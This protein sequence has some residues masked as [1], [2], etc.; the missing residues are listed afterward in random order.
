R[1]SCHGHACGGSYMTSGS[2]CVPQ[3]SAIGRRPS[4][5]RRMRNAR[6]GDWITATGLYDEIELTCTCA[7]LG[8]TN[9]LYLV[10]ARRSWSIDPCGSWQGILPIPTAHRTLVDQALSA[11]P[12][13]TDADRTSRKVDCCCG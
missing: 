9:E 1:R 4:T 6:A 10:G 12:P 3:E 11:R 13:G 5:N 2:Y 7:L 8:N